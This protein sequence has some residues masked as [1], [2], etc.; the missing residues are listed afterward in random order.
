M[1]FLSR[2][3]FLWLPEQVFAT[4]PLSSRLRANNRLSKSFIAVFRIV[5]LVCGSVPRSGSDLLACIM[6]RS[7]PLLGTN[8][9]IDS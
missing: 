5:R 3:S 9:Y 2:L 8:P 4:R 7:L 1:P 6:S